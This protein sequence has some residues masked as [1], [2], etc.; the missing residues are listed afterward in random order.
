MDKIQVTFHGLYF[1]EVLY[2]IRLNDSLLFENSKFFAI[3]NPNRQ[4]IQID[5]LCEQ[6]STMRIK[7]PVGQL[8]IDQLCEQFCTMRIDDIKGQNGNPRNW[9]SLFL[10]NRSQMSDSWFEEMMKNEDLMAAFADTI[11]KFTY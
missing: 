10:G 5:Q 8:Q 2:F 4:A 3:G 6:F 1:C 7:E 11:S 9:W